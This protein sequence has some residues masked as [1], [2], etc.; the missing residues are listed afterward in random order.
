VCSDVEADFRDERG[1]EIGEF[2]AD[3]RR[4]PKEET[5]FTLHAK[6]QLRH[7]TLEV[8]RSVQVLLDGVVVM[9]GPIEKPG[10]VWLRNEHL[11]GE[12]KDPKTG[13][14]CRV[15]YE[16]AELVTGKLYPD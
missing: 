5:D 1:R 4:I 9:E 11:R 12:I 10:R 6:L 3:L 15:R 16:G 8:G 14:V 2:E 7:P 13:Q